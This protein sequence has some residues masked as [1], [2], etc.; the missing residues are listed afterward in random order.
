MTDLA[1]FAADPLCRAPV[2][3]HADAAVFSQ[4]LMHKASVHDH[5]PDT[6]MTVLQQ[7]ADAHRL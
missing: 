7:V 3:V 6:Y 5:L 2:I 4:L 1:L